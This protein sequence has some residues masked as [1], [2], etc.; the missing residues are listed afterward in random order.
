M[1][2]NIGEVKVFKNFVDIEDCDAMISRLE[3][4]CDTQQ[5]KIRDDGRIGIINLEDSIFKNFV[6]KYYIKTK[7]TLK[8][9]FTKYNGY[10]ATKYNEGIG[11][12]THIDSSVGEEM[13]ALMYLNDDYEGGELTYTAPDKTE[14]AIKVNKGDMVYCPSWYPH[15]VNKVTSGTRYFFTVSLLRQD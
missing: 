14:H 6:E 15:G 3:H 10:I 11:M 9:N 7:E 4:L 8:D 1:E 13:G 2:K 5:V 12:A